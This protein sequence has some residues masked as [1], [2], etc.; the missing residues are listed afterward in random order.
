MGSEYQSGGN[1]ELLYLL[2]VMM[3]MSFYFVINISIVSNML[4]LLGFLLGKKIMRIMLWGIFHN[5]AQLCSFGM[6]ANFR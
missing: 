2:N 6:Q 5:A 4:I 1:I 3:M